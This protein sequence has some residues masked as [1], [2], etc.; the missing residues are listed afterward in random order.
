MVE[1]GAYTLLLDRY[2][3]TQAPIPID[4][5][6][7]LTRAR[8]REERAAVDA[9]LAEFF[10][11]SPEGWRHSRCDAEIARFLETEPEREQKRENAK[12][13]QRRA[14]DRRRELFEELRCHGVIPPFDATTAALQKE[15]SRVTGGKGHAPVTRD[16]TATQHQSPDTSHQLQVTDSSGDGSSE[17]GARPDDRPTEM[18]PGGAACRAMRNAGMPA[19]TLNPENAELLEAIRGGATPAEFGATA[20]ELIASG[21]P[22]HMAYVIRTVVGRRRD[23]AAR[24]RQPAN[25]VA[26][27]F[28][29]KT[30]T[31]ATDDELEAFFGRA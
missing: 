26:A 8:T 23:A 24:H 15:L 17:V 1:H 29:G 22:Q 28:D 4:Q 19:H 9:V 5:A 13:R 3:A 25:G 7:R 31:G 14:R 27:N 20:A 12:E 2:Y 16:N 21:K 10:T 11:E 30:Y 6:H 18:T